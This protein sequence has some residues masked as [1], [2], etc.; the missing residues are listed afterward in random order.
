[1]PSD[2][3]RC[4]LLPSLYSLRKACQ[5]LLPI[6]RRLD[7]RAIKRRSTTL[8]V[9]IGESKRGEAKRGSKSPGLRRPP[10]HLGALAILVWP[11]RTRALLHSS[12]R[13]SVSNPPTER[14]PDGAS[15]RTMNNIRDPSRL[16]LG[17]NPL[18]TTSLGPG[19][20]Q[21]TPLSA[22]S[23]T[24]NTQYP[25]HTPPSAIQPYNPQ[26]WIASPVPGAERT[27]DYVRDQPGKRL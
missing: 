16:R 17:L 9:D 20:S 23:L 11:N 1:M 6:G 5:A 3:L 27:H 7:E 26:E 25:T 8:T 15:E 14:S 2:C 19:Y 13:A 22:V 12:Y 21:N 4:G 18:L 24:S 10:I